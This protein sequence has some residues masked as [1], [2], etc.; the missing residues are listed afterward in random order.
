M[1]LW[2]LLPI[3][4]AVGAATNLLLRAD[5]DLPTGK[6]GPPAQRTSELARA[7]DALSKSQDDLAREASALSA[8][9]TPQPTAPSVS[10]AEIGEAV[11]RVL[12]RRLAA[13]GTQSSPAPSSIDGLAM[14]DILRYLAEPG[15][16]PSEVQLLFQEL[17]KA[18]RFDEY[19]AVV[20]ELAAADPENL[21]LGLAV[22][23]AYM[24]K[25]LD[26]AGTPESTDWAA[27]ADQA[28]DRVL[29]RDAGNSQARFGKAIALSNWPDALGKRGEAIAQFEILRGQQEEGISEAGGWRT[30][31][32][33]GGLYERSGEREQALETWEAGLARFPANRE[34]EERLSQARRD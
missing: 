5:E 10:D 3:S 29:A 17:R 11:S 21:D 31:L 2:V 9:E 16:T 27:K 22:A 32:F 30:Y 19:V 14:P 18:G 4:I 24:T 26:A 25:Q 15:R 1:K 8:I 33:L 28:F 23:N 13:G 7:L 34:I 6:S 20:E 12:A